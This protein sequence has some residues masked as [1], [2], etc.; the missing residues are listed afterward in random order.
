M[1]KLMYL[2]S[3]FYALRVST[4]DSNYMYNYDQICFTFQLRGEIGQQHAKVPMAATISPFMSSHL[5]NQPMNACEQA[6]FMSASSKCHVS[7]PSPGIIPSW[8]SLWSLKME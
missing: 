3:A 8:I 7:V 6:S 1:V 4:T 2:C 5:P